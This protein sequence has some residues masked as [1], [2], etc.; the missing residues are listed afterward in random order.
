MLV[1]REEVKEFQKWDLKPIFK[2]DEEWEQEYQKLSKDVDLIEKYNKTMQDTLE[3]FKDALNITED[4][5][6]RLSKLYIYAHLKSDEDTSNGKYQG[7]MSKVLQLSSIASTKTTFVELTIL[8][9]DQKLI[10]KYLEDESLREKEFSFK[11]IRDK[12]PHMLSKEVEETISTLSQSLSASKITFT[13]LNNADIKFKDAIDKDGK[14]HSLSHATYLSLIS[15]KDRVLRK[16]AYDNIYEAYKGHKNTIGS[17]L[18]DNVQTNVTISKLRKY[19]SARQMALSNNLIP[20]SVYDSLL[21][22]VEEKLPVLHR[23]ME[24]RKKYLKLEDMGMYDLSVD[25][26]KNVDIKF[27]FEEAKEIILEALKVMGKDYL[28][29]VRKAFDEKW[30]DFAKNQNK[31]SGAYSS[32]SYDTYPYILISYDDTMDSLYTL[33]HELGHSVHSYYTRKNQSYTYGHYS[34]FLAEVA[35]TTNE[36]L[37]TDYL[38]KKYKDNK[39]IQSTIIN[40]YLDR[41]K[42]TLYRQT[43]F[44]EFEHKIHKDCQDGIPLTADYFS[45]TYYELNKKY[46]G[47]AVKYDENISYEWARIPHFYMNF[48]VYQYATGISAASAFSQMILENKDNAVE[49]YI[50]FL[51]SGCS[52]TPI[53]ILKK[54]GVDMS[55]NKPVLD[56]LN[57]FER[58]LIMF[59][60]ILL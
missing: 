26:L 5:Q 53:N 55:T 6:R 31:R 44:A 47:S 60:E 59:E 10:D 4:I 14:A 57:E 51:K 9:M 45:K 17:T 33:I 30:I 2:S 23:Y 56:C 50:N 48:Y 35:S 43:Q 28:S 24:F 27:T 41:I 34:I 38:I 19:S 16:S 32:G 49:K 29:V 36:M 12:K 20:E 42:A 46:Y 7:Y 8:D 54:A 37:L 15:S 39:D 22:A 13:A 11:E 52:D 21:S 25:L 3:N 58:K 1:K 40:H 18:A